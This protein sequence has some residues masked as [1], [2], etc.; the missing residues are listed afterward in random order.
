MNVFGLPFQHII[1]EPGSITG[2]KVQHIIEVLAGDAGCA[3]RDD[4]DTRAGS[5]SSSSS[6]RR[7]RIDVFSSDQH[8][9]AYAKLVQLLD[10][11]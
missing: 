11:G 9:A 5:S 7:P 4:I 2:Q 8:R 6:S 3:E 1:V 10:H